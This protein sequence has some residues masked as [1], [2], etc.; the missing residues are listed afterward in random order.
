MVIGTAWVL[1]L[2]RGRS[3]P[4]V[5][6]LPVIVGTLLQ[7]MAPAAVS[8]WMPSGPLNP[9]REALTAVL[10]LAPLASW[11]FVWTMVSAHDQKLV[12]AG[13]FAWVRHP[14]YL[15]FLAMLVA[16]AL[17]VGVGWKVMGAVLVYVMGSEMR[18]REEE[19]DLRHRFA[20]EHEAY[21]RAVRWRYLP[22]LR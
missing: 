15:A 19:A 9:S 20:S 11:L 10:V 5:F 14:M 21:A 7:A 4:S 16:T 1:S 12:T 3:A 8:A 22:G 6:S 18:I 2:L 13:P 17:V